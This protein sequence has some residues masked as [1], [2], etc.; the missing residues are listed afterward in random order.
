MIMQV[1]E[2]TLEYVH[3]V[4][5]RLVNRVI[6]AQEAQS[7]SDR[8]I[9]PSFPNNTLGIHHVGLLF[10]KNIILYVHFACMILQG[11]DYFFKNKFCHFHTASGVLF[12]KLIIHMMPT[13]F[14]C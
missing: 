6:R 2:I 13:T 14:K 7:K 12:F 3:E 10:L 8:I 1:S 9:Y 5:I 4:I 11:H